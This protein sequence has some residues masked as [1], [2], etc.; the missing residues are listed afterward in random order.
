MKFI[1]TGIRVR[2]LKRSLRFYTKVMG[3]KITGKGKMLHGGIFVGLA[4]SNTG[5]R[6]ELNWYPKNNKFYVPYK[7]GE[8]LDHLAFE[9]DDVEATV[10]ELVRRGAPVA[11][12]PFGDWRSM[13][14]YVKDP[15]GIW[16]ELIGKK[17][18]KKNRKR[19]A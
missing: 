19:I 5:Q 12:K 6:L 17:T 9:V 13:L 11:V 1:Y 4:D 10:K 2:N 8:E 18:K 15:D 14:A 16:I 7:N 3:L